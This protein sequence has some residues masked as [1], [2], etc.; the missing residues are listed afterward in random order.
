MAKN[1]PRKPASPAPET[2]LEPHHVQ[3]A[4]FELPPDPVADVPPMAAE[5][6]AKSVQSGPETMPAPSEEVPALIAPEWWRVTTL[7]RYAKDGSIHTLAE[8]SFV[9]ERTHDMAELRAQHV[10]MIAAPEGPPIVHS[11]RSMPMAPIQEPYR[12]GSH[13]GMVRRTVITETGERKSEIEAH[14]VKPHHAPFQGMDDFGSQSPGQQ[15][16][17]DPPGIPSEELGAEVKPNP[18]TGEYPE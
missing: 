7:C 18:E 12:G 16:Q 8:G 5:M 10:P 14:H 4:K 2:R 9:S 1:P 15:R 11:E 13:D 6:H 17:E 3:P